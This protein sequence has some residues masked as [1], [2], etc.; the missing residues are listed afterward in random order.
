MVLPFC[1]RILCRSHADCFCSESDTSRDEEKLKGTSPSW[2]H[3]PPLR[4]LQVFLSCL[5][6][7]LV[8][9]LPF[10]LVLFSCSLFLVPSS[11]SLF[12]SLSHPLSQLPFHPLFPLFPL[13]LSFFP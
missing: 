5:L 1:K 13:F 8:L 2:D 6:S 9:F 10:L 7:P 3:T 12:L 4:W 11:L